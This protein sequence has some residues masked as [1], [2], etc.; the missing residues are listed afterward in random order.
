[1]KRITRKRVSV[2]L[3]IMALI[4]TQIPPFEAKAVMSD[5]V[6]E[7]TTL[8]KYE[9]AEATVIIPNYIE[10]IGREAFEKNGSLVNVQIPNSVTSIETGAFARCKNLCSVSIPESVTY[11]APSAFAGCERLEYISIDSD[12]DSY[13]CVD[14]TLM[15]SKGTEIVQVLAGRVGNREKSYTIPAMVEKIDRY[16]FW[17][18]NNIEKVQLNN[19]MTKV[20]AYAFANMEN[21]TTVSIPYNVVEIELKAFE[22]CISLEDVY[23]SPSVV[24]IHDTAFDGCKR[25]NILSEP[26][27]VADAFFESY[28]TDNATQMELEDDEN[29]F[30]VTKDE[31]E[32]SGVEILTTT[33][34]EAD[35]F[36]ANVD[37]VGSNEY[38]EQK[39][40]RDVLGKSK[41]VD[42]KAVVFVDNSKVQV[43]DKDSPT[44][45]IQENS[46]VVNDNQSSGVFVSE[47]EHL[48]EENSTLGKEIADKKY[49]IM[50]GSIA[51]RAYYNE[52][53][54]EEYQI[55]AGVTRIGDFSFAR[56][57]LTS[58]RIPSG[59]NSIGYGAFYNCENLSTIFIPTTVTE[60]EPA[61][62]SNT[63]WLNSWKNGGDVGDFLVVGDGILLAYKGYQSNVI[64]P[65]NIKVIGPEVFKN[66]TEI[67]SVALPDSVKSI[68]EEA[69]YGCT[70]LKNVSGGSFVEEIKD[71]AFGGCSIQTVRITENIKS[72]GLLAYGDMNQTDCVVFMSEDI[73]KLSYEKTA[74]RLSNK[75]YRKSPFEGVS[76]FVVPSSVKN[77]ENTV[78]MDGIMGIDGIICSVIKEPTFQA[79]G[80]VSVRHVSM[81]ENGKV[82]QVPSS[83]WI[84]GKEYYVTNIETNAIPSKYDNNIKND[85]VTLADEG[86][87]NTNVENQEIKSDE[88][89]SNTDATESVSENLVV[90][91]QGNLS[92]K[93]EK[94][95]W[96][97]DLGIYADMTADGKDYELFVSEPVDDKVSQALEQEGIVADDVELVSFDMK[98]VEKGSLIPISR[99]GSEVITVSLPI[100]KVYNEQPV[101]AVCLDSDGQLEYISCVHHMEGD[102]E[103]AVFDVNHFSPYAI[104]CGDKVPQVYQNAYYEKVAAKKAANYSS[105]YGKKDE[106]PDTGDWIHPKWILAIGLILLAI[107]LGLKK[108][109]VAICDKK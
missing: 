100:A 20:P 32:D 26:G 40:D 66:H 98:L 3:L 6:V 22:D 95:S 34:V 21:L 101:V 92:V 59:V 23:L 5:F 47:D 85:E 68:A 83:V 51:E 25:I 104:L 90:A 14:G 67:E 81:D 78:L 10:T 84:Y 17:G 2:I 61:A 29:E 55:P 94:A 36:S 91:K 7:G 58:I 73:P 44:P 63:A 52:I 103:Y 1:M 41:I 39:E 87:I 109:T 35:Y 89:T 65:D 88:I 30:Y 48:S 106:S 64:I 74:T 8:V 75:E 28:V 15:N 72:I 50:D 57:G 24:K 45:E 13:I 54:L 71:R 105:K 82:A 46:V 42:G 86:E 96:N 69:F 11:I 37:Y 19:Y 107:Y 43:Y 99:L 77:F 12:N 62:F 76:V 80:E 31:T 53:E 27:S 79:K 93:V 97:E 33:R 38:I 18:C 102:Q 70:S 56:S 4:V 9:G 16:A 49:V 60:I 108:S